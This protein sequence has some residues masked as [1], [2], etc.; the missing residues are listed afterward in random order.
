MYKID[1]NAEMRQ[2]G[3]IMASSPQTS[4]GEGAPVLARAGALPRA[5]PTLPLNWCASCS[6]SPL[7]K[8]M[9]LMLRP[10]PAMS[11]SASASKASCIKIATV[12]HCRTK[13]N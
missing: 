11:R 7:P 4:E 1:P 3:E 2:A 12:T 8:D 13:Q 5:P 9:V 10:S 6:R